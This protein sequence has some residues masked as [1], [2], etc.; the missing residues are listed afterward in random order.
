MKSILS[1]T[2]I[3]KSAVIDCEEFVVGKN[4]Y[5]GPNVKITCR[6]F[7]AGDYLYMTDGVEVGRGGCNG[8]HSNVTIG[9]NVGI[10][11][12]TII[13]PNSPVTIGD[14]T[15][16]GCD[17]QIWT[18]GAWLDI[19]QGFPADFGPVSIGKNV[20]LPARSIVLPNVTIGDNVVIGIN[21][22]INR[23][24]PSGSFA[25]GS[26]CKVI[27]ENAYPRK[28]SDDGLRSMVWNIID[29]WTELMEYKLKSHKDRRVRRE[30]SFEG[31][32][33][34]YE[35]PNIFL[36]YNGEETIYNIIDKTMEG[37]SNKISE[38]LRDYLRRRGIKI[39]NGKVFKSI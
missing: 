34:R 16:I 26:P 30:I 10:F 23:S 12:N 29:D 21:S 3:S 19:T 5:I 15:G 6:K 37:S 14:N 9:D 25:A 18:H 20:W 28:V 33:I 2:T 13:N 39:Y 8:V 4:S 35:K 31:T 1:K 38:D 36:N 7:I 17:V 22:I 11:E 27:K 32:K 24:L